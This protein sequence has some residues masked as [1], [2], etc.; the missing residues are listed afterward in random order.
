M[1]QWASYFALSFSLSLSL[2]LCFLRWLCL[3]YCCCCYRYLF[4]FSR[5]VDKWP[6][7]KFDVGNNT[8]ATVTSFFSR[9]VRGRRKFFTLSFSFL[10]TI[11]FEVASFSLFL[12][13]CF[14]ISFLSV[15]IE[16]LMRVYQTHIEDIRRC[17][18]S[19][20]AV[21]PYASLD[22]FSLLLLLL[23]LTVPT[24]FLKVNVLSPFGIFRLSI[25]AWVSSLNMFR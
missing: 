19:L 9:G 5:L 16:W 25:F 24:W 6:G 23:L 3:C 4:C 7:I 12:G 18:L 8:E 13:L 20:F 21:E 1:Q 22:F 2:S 14:L 15:Q 17:L 10:D 11:A